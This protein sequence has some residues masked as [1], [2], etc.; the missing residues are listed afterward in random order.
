[1][2]DVEAPPWLKGLPLAPEYHPTEVEFEDPIGYILKIEQEA[3]QFGICKIVPPY[4]KAPKR[5]VINNLNSALA[6][7]HDASI[8]TAHGSS[9]PMSRSMGP[10]RSM[11]GTETANVSL[12]L[13]DG[14]KARFTTRRQQLGWTVHKSNALPQSVTHKLVWQSGD[15]YTLEQFEAKAKLFSRNRLGTSREMAPMSIET[16]FWKAACEKSIAIEYANDIPGSAFAEPRETRLDSSLRFLK[17]KWGLDEEP[18]RKQALEDGLGGQEEDQ[19]DVRGAEAQMGDEAEIW[20]GS[21]KSETGH[22]S[23]CKLSDSA[24]NMRN[25][26]RSPGSLLRFMPDEVPGLSIPFTC[27]MTYP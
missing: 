20:K 11:S 27:C 9:T 22:G 14:G 17:H 6:L 2:A 18:H 13:Q 25:V 12:G 1:M 15:S 16:L 19:E 8:T 23:G 21:S 26:A 24:W 5:I 7:S 10:S 3:V 4:L